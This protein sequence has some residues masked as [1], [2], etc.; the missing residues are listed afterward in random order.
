MAGKQVFIEGATGSRRIGNLDFEN[1]EPGVRT[2]GKITQAAGLVNGVREIG[3]PVS[4]DVHV[5]LPPHGLG[6]RL[7]KLVERRTARSFCAPLG[8]H[9]EPEL[10]RRPGT[11]PLA[12]VVTRD[13]VRG[14]L[15]ELRAERS[16]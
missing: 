10:A 1:P 9:L 5:E 16:A 13:E 6:P 8:C 11:G 12:R 2:G 4:L 3:D 14:G 7:G 15:E